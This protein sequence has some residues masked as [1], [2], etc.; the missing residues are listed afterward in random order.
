MPKDT[1]KKKWKK[2]K[3]NKTS[4]KRIEE[5]EGIVDLLILEVLKGGG[6]NV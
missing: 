5:L 2:D 4:Q 1:D 3:E 6:D